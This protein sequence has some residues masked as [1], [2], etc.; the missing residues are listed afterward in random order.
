MSPKMFNA[1][2]AAAASGERAPHADP[3]RWRGVCRQW[4]SAGDL[5]LA[6]LTAPVVGN[7]RFDDAQLVALMAAFSAAADAGRQFLSYSQGC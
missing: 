3:M 4:S 6:R 5:M 7:Y 2:S 1:L